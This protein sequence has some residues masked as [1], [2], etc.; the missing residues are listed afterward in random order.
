VNTWT[1]EMCECTY[2]F[3]YWKNRVRTTTFGFGFSSVLGK[4]RVLVRFVVAGFGYFPISSFNNGGPPA[5][6]LRQLRMYYAVTPLGTPKLRFSRV[7][8]FVSYLL[9]RQTGERPRIG[10]V[11][12]TGCRLRQTPW[13]R[14]YSCRHN[15]YHVTVQ[16]LSV[17][18]SAV[19]D[20]LSL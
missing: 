1:I 2:N 17:M 14:R 4:T 3:I 11:E 19:C 20:A 15:D 9:C 18:L 8:S 13:W 12:L 10:S 7:C 5:I 6:T 16:W